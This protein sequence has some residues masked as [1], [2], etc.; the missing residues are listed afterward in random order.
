[1]SDADP[2]RDP[3]ALAMDDHR[4]R[5]G[6]MPTIM[7]IHSADYPA[8]A[9]LLRQAVVDGRPLTDGDLRRALGMGD[10]PPGAEI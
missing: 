8:I 6:D 9:A 2:P 1:V 5:F 7:G 3:L 10:L 4:A